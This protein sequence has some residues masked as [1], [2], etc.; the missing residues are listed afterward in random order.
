MLNTLCTSRH[1]HE[2]YPWPYP[3]SWLVDSFLPMVIIPN[4]SGSVGP[5]FFTNQPGSISVMAHVLIYND[6]GKN[7]TRVDCYNHSLHPVIFLP[8]V[9]AKQ[10]LAK[11]ND[12]YAT[13]PA[14]NA[15]LATCQPKTFG[16]TPNKGLSL[17]PFPKNGG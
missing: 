6:T 10:P 4:N 12:V 11:D 1:G 16:E 2:R 5:F 13:S 8:R 17:Q 15:T 14:S 3:I 9:S 7:V